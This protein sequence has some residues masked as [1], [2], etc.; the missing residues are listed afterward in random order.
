MRS[1]SK[2]DQAVPD[3]F[4]FQCSKKGFFRSHSQKSATFTVTSITV[5]LTMQHHI[6]VWNKYLK[7]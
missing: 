7:T 1:F 6:K 2:F 5:A 3:I 4:E